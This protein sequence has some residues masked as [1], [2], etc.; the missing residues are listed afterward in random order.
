MGLNRV[1]IDRISEI[2]MVNPIPPEGGLSISLRLSN[3]EGT[4]QSHPLLLRSCLTHASDARWRETGTHQKLK[5]QW[6]G[7]GTREAELRENAHLQGHLQELPKR[8]L[9]EFSLSPITPE[10]LP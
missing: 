1:F 10:K 5:G 9:R 6:E 4:H 2:S 3:L 8:T 7:R